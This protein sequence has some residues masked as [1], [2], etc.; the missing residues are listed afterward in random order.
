MPLARF[1]A[2]HVTGAGGSGDA[3]PAAAARGYLAQHAL[4]E[5]VP[6]LRADICTPDYC[7]LGHGALHAVNA[8]LG[9]AST[10]TPL[11][12]DP[13]H[14]ILAQVVGA[15]YVR[16]Y[17]PG[18]GGSGALYPHATGHCTNTSRVDVGAPDA[19][20]FP[21]FAAAPF[22][23]VELCAGEARGACAARHPAPPP[24]SAADSRPWQ[25]LYIPPGWWH[26]VLART[27]SFSVSFWW[28]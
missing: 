20:A 22:V 21:R 1:L 15:K 13:H 24:A 9:P 7:S 6:A 19:A 16:L 28:D 17:A 14:N 2:A 23:D 25:A 18:A 4:F 5:Q 27:S 26:Y 10:V 12:H 11:H 3:A 8:W